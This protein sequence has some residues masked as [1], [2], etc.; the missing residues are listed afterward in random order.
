MTYEQLKY[1][2]PEEFKRLC[3][4]HFGTFERMVEVLRPHLER[5]GKRGGQPKLSVEDQLLIS[6]EYWR[7]Y[8]TY[9]HIGVKLG[10]LL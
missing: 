2:K 7:E 9:F 10:K 8:R 1:L 4:I 5:T 3:G 6:L